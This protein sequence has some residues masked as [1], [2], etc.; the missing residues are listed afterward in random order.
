MMASYTVSK[1]RSK[2]LND[3]NVKL[4]SQRQP[5]YSWIFN[6][7]KENQYRCNR[8]FELGKQRTIS[9]TNG[10]VGGWKNPEDEH[11]VDCLP[12]KD[13]TLQVG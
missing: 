4:E 7:T 11:H 3:T 5:G 12:Q 2:Y 9:V 6:H 8:C 13:S 1:I 10:E